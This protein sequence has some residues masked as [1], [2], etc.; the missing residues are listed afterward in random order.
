MAERLRLHGYWRSSASYRVRIALNLKGL[1]YE[2]APV[3]LVRDGGEQ[4]Q[5]AFLKLNPQGLVPVLQHGE[6]IVRQSLAIIE[7]LD[8]LH[9]T[10][11][12]LPTTARDR[13]RVRALALLVA[14]DVHPL[15][16][17]RVMQYLENELGVDDAA[18]RAWMLHWM[19]EGLTG[20][21]AQVNDNP[22]TGDFC[23]G[24][25]PGLADCCLVPQLY[26]ARRYELDLRPYPTLCR[27]EANCNALTA[28]DLA[29]PER[30]PDAP[31]G[32]A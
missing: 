12:L 25:M 3:H 9:P 6:R 32:I 30:Q 15:C 14:C 27:I 2:Q 10:P 5:S 17:L 29:R 1:A 11:P 8:E 4:H 18:R 21:E 22:S 19:H 31:S 13:A 26:N 7:Y 16:N 23:E 28:F 24:D 20:M